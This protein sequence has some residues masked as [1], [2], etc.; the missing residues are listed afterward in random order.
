MLAPP[1]GVAAADAGRL[2]ASSLRSESNAPAAGLPRLL[3]GAGV[4]G[5]MVK[6]VG[7]ISPWP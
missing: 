5:A 2:A 7:G 4:D 6:G 1:A 3:V